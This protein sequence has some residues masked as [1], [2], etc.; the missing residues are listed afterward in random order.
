MSDP[1]FC[2]TLRQKRPGVV[3]KWFTS[4]ALGKR[5]NLYVTN[6][7]KRTIEKNGGLIFSQKL[8]LALTEQGLT[9]EEA[10]KVVQTAA[11]KSRATGK[12]F[13]DLVLDDKDAL[14]HLKKEEIEKIFDTRS[15]LKHVD[16][17]FRRFGL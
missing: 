4:E 3:R 15:Y 7:A 9:R 17:A 1:T 8:L 12:L 11:M 6:K 16:T 2:S 13:K 10:Y 14:R 5:F